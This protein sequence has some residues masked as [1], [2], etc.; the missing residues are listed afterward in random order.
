[1]TSSLGEVRVFADTQWECPPHWVHSVTF[2]EERCEEVKSYQKYAGLVRLSLKITAALCML[3]ACCPAQKTADHT[4]IT[5]GGGYSTTAR[6]TVNDSL[7]LISGAVVQKGTR[8]QIT[9]LKVAKG[10]VLSD[11]K[12]WRLY[13]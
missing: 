1:M 4:R 9:S 10:T 13:R 11:V 2:K 3:A 6:F 12:N 5:L 7:T 8:F